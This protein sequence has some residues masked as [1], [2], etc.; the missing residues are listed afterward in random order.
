MVDFLSWYSV[1][2]QNELLLHVFWVKATGINLK[3]CYKDNIDRR[4]DAT[5]G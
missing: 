3:S 5:R 1:E 2:P 4:R